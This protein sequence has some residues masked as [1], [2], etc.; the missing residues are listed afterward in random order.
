MA[1]V[2]VYVAEE[3]WGMTDPEVKISDTVRFDAATQS[4]FYK[5]DANELNVQALKDNLFGKA[6]SK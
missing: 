3:V 5:T 2:T 4:F 6:C 1:G